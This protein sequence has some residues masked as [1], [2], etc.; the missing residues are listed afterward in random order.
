MQEF[1]RLKPHF[2]AAIAYNGGT[3]TIDQMHQ[4]LYAGKYELWPSA[5]A[6]AITEI[7]ELPNKTYINIVLGGGDLAELQLI[8]QAIEAKARELKLN[9]VMIVGRRGWKKVLPNF[10][11]IATLLIKEI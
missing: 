7:C 9:G 1:E 6:G 8:N 3:Q 11:E 2:I 5:N 4:G 10:E